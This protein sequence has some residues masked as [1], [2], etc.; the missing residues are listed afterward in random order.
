MGPAEVYIDL[1]PVGAADFDISND[2][3]PDDM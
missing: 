3:I 1:V 2:V